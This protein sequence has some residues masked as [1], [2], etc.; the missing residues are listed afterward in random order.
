MGPLSIKRRPVARGENFALQRRVRSRLPP[1][2]VSPVRTRSALDRI[3]AGFLRRSI[4]LAWARPGCRKTWRS[5]HALLGLGD[6]GQGIAHPRHA[7]ALPAGAD[8]RRN[9]RFEPRMGVA[10]L[11]IDGDG[12]LWRPTLESLRTRQ[13]SK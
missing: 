9:R 8:T 5:H 11:I 1:P 3:R 6:I 10:F 2:A 13:V 12:R 4:A 7:A